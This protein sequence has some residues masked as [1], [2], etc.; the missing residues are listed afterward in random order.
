MTAP[1]SPAEQP[2]RRSNIDER[3]RPRCGVWSP[4]LGPCIAEWPH[5]HDSAGHLV[6]P[7][8]PPP[9][10]KNGATMSVCAEHPDGHARGRCPRCNSPSPEL[11]PAVQ[12]EG[13]V[14]VCEHPFHDSAR[15]PYHGFRQE[16]R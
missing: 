2:P 9:G 14:H 4:M 11:H 5:E 7:A 8:E 13:E 12:C 6:R 16:V 15:R 10:E 1:E 3:G